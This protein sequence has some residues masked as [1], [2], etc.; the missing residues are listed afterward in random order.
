MKPTIL[1]N[2]DF[3]PK[4]QF[5]YSSKIKINKKLKMTE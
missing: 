4:I 2:V 3:I 1:F 5:H